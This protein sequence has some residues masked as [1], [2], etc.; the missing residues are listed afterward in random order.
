MWRFAATLRKGGGEGPNLHL[1][2]ST[3]LESPYLQ[4]ELPSTFVAHVG[5]QTPWRIVMPLPAALQ[6]SHQNGGRVFLIFVA[7]PIDLR[8]YSSRGKTVP[9]SS[10]GVAPGTRMCSAKPDALGT[11][12]VPWPLFGE[13]AVCRS[14]RCVPTSAIDA[15]PGCSTDDNC[16][17]RLSANSRSTTNQQD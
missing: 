2:H 1:L 12:R 14:Q 15:R 10:V 13:F 11:S 4:T 3:M 8:S 17:H 5:S 9:V 7:D 16:S 6:N